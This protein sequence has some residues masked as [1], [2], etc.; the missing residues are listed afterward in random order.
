LNGTWCF[1]GNNVTGQ[2]VATPN[3][4]VQMG[5]L[6]N[7]E[8]QCKPPQEESYLVITGSSAAGPTAGNRPPNAPT[9]P[10][11]SYEP[12][13]T[14]PQGSGVQLAWRDNGDPD[15]DALTFGLFVMRFDTSSE[16]WIPAPSFGDESGNAAAIW[17]PGTSYTYTTQA[18]LQQ[19]TSY[20]WGVIACEVNRTADQPCAWSGWSV[21]RVQ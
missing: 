14:V 6:A 21:F 17:I 12:P 16:T 3:C 13:V 2:E 15:G 4:Q 7:P 9:V 8:R 20:S 19:G 11:G 5:C 10:P 18:G 1:C